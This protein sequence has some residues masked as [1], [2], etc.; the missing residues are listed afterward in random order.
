[1]KTSTLWSIVALGTVGAPLALWV[2]MTGTGLEDVQVPFWVYAFHG[3]N[4][5][6]FTFFAMSAHFAE[7]RETK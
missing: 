4:A 3:L 5:A 1:M 7:M 2:A 6:G